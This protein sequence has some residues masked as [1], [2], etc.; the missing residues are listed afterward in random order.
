MASRL[1]SII[2]GYLYKLPTRPLHGVGRFY[3][4][5]EG[6]QP[7]ASGKPRAGRESRL[8]TASTLHPAHCIQHTASSTL[9]P[10]HCIQHTAASTL[11]PAHCSQHT[12]SSTLQ[13]AHCSQHTACGCLGLSVRQRRIRAIETK[14]AQQELSPEREQWE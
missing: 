1:Q 14:K 6:E 2:M 11:H 3:C 10:A 9:H 7:E 4:R 5:G 13:P 8:H 12:A